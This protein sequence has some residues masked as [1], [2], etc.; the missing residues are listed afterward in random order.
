[1]I[2]HRS[3][4]CRNSF[5]PQV[6][7]L[8]KPHT[9]D[10]H[11]FLL[12]GSK[13]HYAPDRPIQPLA[14]F[15]DIELDPH[16]QN[17]KGWVHHRMKRVDLKT[18]V[19]EL[20][21]VG[22]K[23]KQV[24]IANASDLSLSDG[25]TSARSME[26]SEFEMTE[27]K[28]IIPLASLG[29]VKGTDDGSPNHRT[30]DIAIEFE[31]ISPKKGL[32]FI[33]PTKEEPNRPIQVWSQGED[34][35][36]HHWFPLLDYPNAKLAS[37]MRIS[38]PKPFRAIS[39]GKMISSLKRGDRNLFHYRL[40]V[41]H[42]SYLISL[43]VGEFEFWKDQVE[44]FGDGLV[45]KGG[46]IDVEYYV[47]KGRKADGARAFSNTPEMIR[48]F[49][50]KLGV[51]YPYEKYSQTAVREFIIG[52]MEN[53]S[54]T[55]QSDRTLHDERAHLD[56]SSDGLVAHE[57]AHQWFGN[58]VT[59]RDWTHV[60]LNEGFATFLERVWV[61]NDKSER[62]GPDEADYYGYY[63]LKGYLAEFDARHSR[64]IVCKEFTTPNDLFDGHTYLKGQVVL[65]LLRAEL[66]EDSFWASIRHYLNQ[67]REK[68][69]ETIDLARAIEETTGRNMRRFFDQWVYR[70]GHPN[71]E[72]E[73]EYR[74]EE[75]LVKISVAQNQVV[76]DTDIG[77]EGFTIPYFDFTL[78]IFIGFENGQGRNQS[79]KISG[80]KSVMMFSCETKPSFVTIDPK[81]VVPKTIAFKQNFHASKAQLLNDTSV[82]G[83]IQAIDSLLVMAQNGQPGLED[84]FYEAYGK[85]RF[86]GIQSEIAKGLCRL[87]TEAARSY[88]L[89]ILEIES[90]PHILSDLVKA[91]LGFRDIRFSNFFLKNASV[92]KSVFVEGAMT[93]AAAHH[94]QSVNR[95]PYLS[96]QL[97]P[98]LF[99]QLEKESFNAEVTRDALTSLNGLVKRFYSNYESEMNGL[100]EKIQGY[101]V[102]QYDYLIRA[103]AVQL[104]GDSF[105]VLT[106][107]FKSSV[108][109]IFSE[110]SYSDSLFVRKAVIDALELT[111]DIRSIPILE[112]MLQNEPQTRFQRA[113]KLAIQ[114]VRTSTEAGS[115][116][117]K[118]SRDIDSLSDKY[119]KVLSELSSIKADMKPKK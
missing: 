89:K 119:S 48:V 96:D 98:F 45:Q 32:Y 52:G 75:K 83:I 91:S 72:V 33:H 54:S 35:D 4:I 10:H 30:F 28:V 77:K 113:V 5:D 60:W 99:R 15:L 56:F 50:E 37:E 40:E 51:A 36:N 47:E 3:H 78:P 115:I 66:G 84:L 69:V 106:S 16:A 116:N 71:L 110:L 58:L 55:T 104:M 44:L 92:Q 108:L 63:D 111:N 61:E 42:V 23:V 29:E 17:V 53:T 88:I 103:R 85:S 114:S 46:K 101:A 34:E 43:V 9:H 21:Q 22:I 109:N 27:D 24:K 19:C 94:Y 90:N 18:T 105:E 112:R 20:D 57:L 80:Q 6:F 100:F 65:N 117:E 62:G 26:N 102:G 49:Q 95:D 14:L 82:F 8:R 7:V 81:C 31:V 118:M 67:N 41:K 97:I 93:V 59:C 76:G 1:M 79:L 107:S 74:T 39:N 70:S 25:A 12:P 11:R 64:P 68:C 86:W 13:P 73:I 2:N 87:G 38:V